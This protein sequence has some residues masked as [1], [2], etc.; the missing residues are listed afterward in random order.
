MIGWGKREASADTEW[1]I[2]KG[3]AMIQQGSGLPGLDHSTC[4]VVLESD[5]YVHGP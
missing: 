1:K 5:G 2:G 3:F 4:D